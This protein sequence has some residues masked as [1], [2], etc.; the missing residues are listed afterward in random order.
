MKKNV[1]FLVS[2]TGLLLASG[3]AQQVQD[4]SALE[5]Q[6]A[7]LQQQVADLEQQVEMMQKKSADT[8]AK[9]QASGPSIFNDPLDNFFASAEFWETTYDVGYA[10]CSNGCSQRYVAGNK[11]CDEKPE[12]EQEECRSTVSR[13]NRQCQQEC[14]ERFDTSP[15]IP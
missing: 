1:C 9:L 11:A 13:N 12:A 6:V 15:D 2:L 3:C 10:E 5:Q 4:D 14:V 7:T 8:R